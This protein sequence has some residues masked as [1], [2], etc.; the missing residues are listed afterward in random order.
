[1]LY[2]VYANGF[3]T[4]IGEAS[5]ATLN[6]VSEV[7]F[8]CKP[9]TTTGVALAETPPTDY[10]LAPP[11]ADTDAITDPAT[12]LWY[13]DEIF[14]TILGNG[15]IPLSATGATYATL[16]D[17]AAFPEDTNVPVAQQAYTLLNTGGYGSTYLTAGPSSVNGSINT[18]SNPVGDCIVS[19]TD[20]FSNS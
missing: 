10:Y 11:A 7:G 1:L 6:Y 13:H 3:N 5:A 8:V 18:T 15:F 14:D 16:A 4:N 12:G 19:T 20:T 2:N 17:G 9:Q